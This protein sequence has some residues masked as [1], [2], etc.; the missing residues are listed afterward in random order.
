MP[1]DYSKYPKDWKAIRA[2]ILERDDHRCKFCGVPN[3]A[4]RN[5][6]TGR[7]FRTLID[8]IESNVR[9]SDRGKY[10]KIVLTIA[11]IE[12][13]DPMD[14]RDENLAALCQR[15][16]NRLDMPMRQSN[17]RRTRARNAGQAELGVEVIR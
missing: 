17:A 6:K 1:C 2:R 10:S 9:P 5:Y 3:G 15:C 14:C 11:H 7:E 12:N 8:L 16:H 4:Y 13:P